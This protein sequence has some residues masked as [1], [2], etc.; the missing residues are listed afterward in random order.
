MDAIV[1]ILGQKDLRNF[2]EYV[3]IDGETPD[4][5]AFKIYGDILR[6]NQFH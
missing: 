3:V 6:R 1:L 2:V 4:D 5:V